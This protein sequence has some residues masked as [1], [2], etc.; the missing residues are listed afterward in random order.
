MAHDPEVRP[1]QSQ[2][3]GL[4]STWR[5][6]WRVI[7]ASALLLMICGPASAQ[8]V[9][10]VN[11]ANTPRP[12][13]AN[14]VNTITGI[15]LDDSTTVYVVGMY[16][17]GAGGAGNLYSAVT[18]GG[19]PATGLMNN[20][21]N[22]RT[23]IAYWIN[24][25]T[26]AG[27]TL[28]FNYA[29]NGSFQGFA[30]RY[31][32]ANVNTN[33]GM[34]VTSGGLQAGF[35]ASLTTLTNNSFVISYIGANN[36]STF[37]VNPPLA[38]TDTTQQSAGTGGASMASATNTIATPG[39]VTTSWNL[40]GAAVAQQSVG[41]IA[42]VPAD[43][44]APIVAGSIS[45][46]LTA[47][48]AAY[49][50]TVSI[51][52][53]HSGNLTSVNVDLTS[54]G[55]ASVN[56][57]VQSADPNVW[58]N[59]F[60]VPGGA[61]P[62]TYDL[63][64]TATQD[65]APVTGTGSVAINVASPSAPVLVDDTLPALPFSMYVGQGVRFSASFAAP[66]FITYRWQKSSDDF[67]YTD[68]PGA[69]SPTYTIPSVTLGDAGYYRLQA[70]NF[71]GTNASTGRQVTVNDATSALYIWSAPIPFGG[72]TAEQILTNFPATNKI[73]GALAAQSGASPISVV[74]TNAGNR[75]VVFSRDGTWASLSGGVSYVAN[76]NTN[77]TGNANLNS[78]L[79]V[80]YNGGTTRNITM[81][82]L[83]VGKK[84][85]VQLFALDN[86]SGLTPAASAQNTTFQDPSDPNGITSEAY[87]MADNFY[88]LGTFTANSTQMTIQQNLPA[89]SGNVNGLVLR[90]VGW[91]PAPYITVQQ[92]STNNFVGTR[93]SMTGSAAGD[94]TIASPT[95]T[96]Q[97]AS[98]PAGGPYNTVLT[99]GVKYAGVTTPTLT[100]SNLVVGD[101]DS[102]YVLKA[103]NGG[104]TTISKEARVYVQ[105]LPIP[106]P[107]NSYGSAVLAL[108]NVANSRLVGL[109]QLNETNDPSTGLLIAYDA[110]GKGKSGTYGATALNGYNG[111]L[112]PQ[113]PPF[114]GFAANQGALQTGAGGTGDATSVV[115]LPPLHITNGVATTFAMWIYP[116]ATVGNYTWLL[117]NRTQGDDSGF[118][119]GTATGGPSGQRNLGFTWN[120]SPAYS[121]FAY[122]SG[123]F[124][125][126]D[127]WNFVV[128][129]LS[130]NAATF[131]LNY[132]DENGA[133]FSGKAA[134]TTATY[135]QN[136]WNGS[137]I[138]IGGDPAN[139][140][141]TIFP[142]R[143]ANVTVFNSALTDDQIYDL[144]VSGFQNGGFPAGIV[145]QP[146]AT[147]TNYAGYTLQL[148]AIPGG[149]KPIT[150]QWKLN[151]AN[152]VDG[153]Y[154]GVIITGAKSN[155]LT[156]QNVTASYQGVYTMA[157]TN[158]LGG[159]VS[160]NANVTI[161]V[162]QA[163]PGANLV[164]RWF[165]GT[166]S[167]ADLSGFSP[168]GTHDAF[169]V[170]TNGTNYA[171]TNSVPPGKTG[172]SL[173]LFGAT[174]MGITN[175]LQTDPGYQTTFDTGL[176]SS[177]SVSAW[178]RGQ[179]GVWNPFVS[180]NGETEGWQLRRSA[181][182]NAVF[183]LRGTGGT[184]DPA[185]A[186][187]G[188]GADGL[189]H[190]YVGTYDFATAT[191]VLYVDGIMQNTSTGDVT[192]YTQ[193]PNSRLVLGGRSLPGTTPVGM[194]ETN[195][196][197][198][199]G[200]L[201]DVRIYNIALTG[202][203]QAYLATPPPAQLP[204]QSVSMSF[205]PG[206]PGQM[207]LSWLNGGKLLQSTNV[208]G[209]WVT[210]NAATPPYTV[211]TTNM[212]AAFYRIFF[213]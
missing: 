126:N 95:I 2:R 121:T 62:G 175:T 140:G 60:T 162:P 73:A 54:I 67:T 99:D 85:Q 189:W 163:P 65:A 72:L 188:S 202:P 4:T 77:K 31:E 15:D 52:P 153:W 146:P 178:A 115:N 122:N 180:K 207:V 82:G 137:P 107:A 29:N 27:Q 142:G 112:A 106:P 157:V 194:I 120:S 124:P 88:M 3:P 110:S 19:V 130:T 9:K 198:T 38:Q 132:V 212:P 139:S 152:L 11:W 133:A 119:F 205:T 210:N 117:G 136:R 1:E 161:L 94:T 26:A 23:A 30:W 81:S 69:V 25:N 79:N 213:P 12:A 196:N 59:S 190:H 169:G 171:F 34:V 75:P 103:S 151:G 209:P 172:S 116:T 22:T 97:W 134:D 18:F 44:G 90:S 191:R 86:R 87:T 185:G 56:A 201:Y 16:T 6:R 105:S 76:L 203:Q 145:Q 199:G 186:A 43:V 155:V 204:P 47:P 78:V 125:V 208:T 118:G 138:W 83:V 164:G 28:S 80:G 58:T 113:P 24:P 66:G 55:G 173:R 193:S 57:L 148:N 74:L 179:P 39:L 100:I 187:G 149:N 40:T 10:V 5:A 36:D 41:A 109:W 167:L 64:V 108:T 168:A 123:L 182:A 176:A 51:D 114:N 195:A 159:T 135:T 91:D 42:F 174:S 143:I 21:A 206:N 96:Y 17:D 211:P 13:Q 70:S 102:V 197:F 170:G 14:P 150:N 48:G 20:P 200:N 111:V 32:L 183:T 71:L 158:S 128:F 177:F 33:S 7:L 92:Q 63:P 37:S 156:I 104:G 35:S 49:I 101:G 166:T 46:S 181:G 147:V 68:I 129:V 98:G 160:S 131:Y 165:D 8:F 141:S 93:V 53:F 50:V 192:A 154:N 89:S 61:L 184:I 144:F 84:Y 127:R 45:P